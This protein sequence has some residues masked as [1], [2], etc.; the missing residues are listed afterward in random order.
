MA[1]GIHEARAVL[2]HR[3]SGGSVARWQ[4]SLLRVCCE[5]GSVHD[6]VSVVEPFFARCGVGC[7]I[8]AFLEVEWAAL[9]EERR[10]IVRA[11][12][13]EGIVLASREQPASHR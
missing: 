5:G 4:A 2:V 13:E 11:T 12:L 9:R 7:D 8:L 10:R 3:V 1:V 6:R